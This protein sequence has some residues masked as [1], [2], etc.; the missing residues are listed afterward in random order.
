MLRYVQAFKS[1][2]EDR[3]NSRNKAIKEKNDNIRIS[4]HLDYAKDAG[5]TKDFRF[6]VD[7]KHKIKIIFKNKFIN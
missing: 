7:F 3:Q 6:H 5:Y 1:C 4:S 2:S